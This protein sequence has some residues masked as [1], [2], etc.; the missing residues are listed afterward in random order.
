MSTDQ[1]PQGQRT[2]DCGAD[3]TEPQQAAADDGTGRRGGTGSGDGSGDGSVSS[4]GTGRTGPTGGAGSTSS[5]DRG[6]P[7]RGRVGSTGSSGG[8]GAKLRGALLVIALFPLLAALILNAQCDF[9]PFG[10]WINP[11]VLVVT[12]VGV[13]VLW[14]M[15]GK[16][17]D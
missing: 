1:T 9:N 13:A 6:S 11:V 4:G 2:G 5:G 12:A 10:T 16:R 17:Q 3:R 8:A 7:G 14:G 15:T